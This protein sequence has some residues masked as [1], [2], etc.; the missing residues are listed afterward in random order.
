MMERFFCLD[1]GSLAQLSR[2]GRCGTCGSEAVVS[3][4]AQ[5]PLVVSR[6]AREV[7][8]LNRIFAL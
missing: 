5:K 3:Q 2:H 8:E 1:C 6:D 4:E 7:A